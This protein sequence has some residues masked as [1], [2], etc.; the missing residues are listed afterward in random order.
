MFNYNCPHTVACPRFHVP[1]TSFWR[2]FQSQRANDLL[3]SLQLRWEP[4]RPC[5]SSRFIAADNY[6][7]PQ[8]HLS[9]EARESNP[10]VR[11]TA[12]QS[13]KLTPTYI[14]YYKTTMHKFR[15]FNPHAPACALI[16]SVCLQL[17]RFGFI[18]LASRINVYERWRRALSTIRTFCNKVKHAGMSY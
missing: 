15:I 13:P 14:P 18:L 4:C 10:R 12:T 6:A 7:S 2:T 3:M 9:L 11:T 17:Q 1:Y 8:L 5:S 16:W